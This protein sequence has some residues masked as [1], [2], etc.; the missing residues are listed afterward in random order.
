VI[1]HWRAR[2]ENLNRP[3]S[4]ITL[5]FLKGR[6]E[7]AIAIDCTLSSSLQEKTLLLTILIVICSYVSPD[8][9]MN[10]PIVPLP[11]AR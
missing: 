3:H 6:G 8:I 1:Q 9:G 4:I 2:V 11:D 5:G 7:D 10:L